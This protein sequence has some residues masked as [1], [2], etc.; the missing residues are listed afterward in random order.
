MMLAL[1]TMPPPCASIT[2][3][4]TLVLRPKSSA[5]TIRYRLSAFREGTPLFCQPP[6]HSQA[7]R[8]AGSS[9]HAQFLGPAQPL[10]GQVQPA[11]VERQEERVRRLRFVRYQRG[12]VGQGQ[13][14]PFSR[15][16]PAG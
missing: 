10:H 7:R 15:G 11:V 14:L 9:R 6:A 3:R 16:P 12:A 5:L 1:V 8:S 4:F 2:P 13:F